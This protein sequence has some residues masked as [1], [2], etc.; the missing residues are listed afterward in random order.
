MLHVSL[1]T[2]IGTQ[3]AIIQK[4]AD[5]EVKMEIKPLRSA[6]GCIHACNDSCAEPK[7][8]RC[9][10]CKSVFACQDLRE[11]A[12]PA[13][14]NSDLHPIQRYSATTLTYCSFKP[15]TPT[16]VTCRLGRDCVVQVELFI[17][18]AVLARQSRLRASALDLALSGTSIH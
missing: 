16:H 17:S 15:H 1:C 4:I 9:E 12:T 5:W 14:R 3:Q 18:P 11:C 13:K 6:L 8:L 2:V 7:T 10:L